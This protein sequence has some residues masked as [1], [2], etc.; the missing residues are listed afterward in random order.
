MVI[1]MRII[2]ANYTVPNFSWTLYNNSSEILAN[3]YPLYTLYQ[4]EKKWA[5]TIQN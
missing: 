4:I 5:Y 2:L 1:K 3:L